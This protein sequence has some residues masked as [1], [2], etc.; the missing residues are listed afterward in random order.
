MTS[1][2][3][4]ALSKSQSPSSTI[5]RFASLVL[6]CV[7]IVALGAVA[8]F[9]ERGIVVGRDWVIHTYQV[10]SQLS[11]LASGGHACTGW[12][13][14]IRLDAGHLTPSPVSRAI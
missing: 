14:R 2:L 10:R 7:A 3:K 9:T 13:K 1:N 8:Y 4:S 6:V 5:I 12:R 11:D